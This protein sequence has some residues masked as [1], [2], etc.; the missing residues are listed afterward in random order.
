MTF[1]PKTYTNGQVLPA[2][3]LNDMD[4]ND[5]HCREESNYYPIWTVSLASYSKANNNT[6]LR[7][8]I[9]GTGIGTAFTSTG[10]KSEA[11]ISL[12]AFSDG[13]HAISV[14]YVGQDIVTAKF[15][16]TPDMDYLTWWVGINAVVGAA[17]PY[18]HSFGNMT[19]I[20][21]RQTKG[22]T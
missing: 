3:D 9:D 12:A 16:K 20:C 2:L 8:F 6:S 14:G 17:A 1:V 22:W 7:L 4:A 10:A 5:D 18:T 21:H 15:V 19:V 13:L 11:D